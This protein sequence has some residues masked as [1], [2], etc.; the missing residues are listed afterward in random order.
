MCY[1]IVR[2]FTVTG[3]FRLFYYEFEASKS[4]AQSVNAD[5]NVSDSLKILHKIRRNFQHIKSPY[6]NIIPETSV[7]N[8]TRMFIS[9][10]CS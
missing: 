3:S 7:T 2:N 5:V 10:D 4:V 1:T 8:F 6:R 9:P